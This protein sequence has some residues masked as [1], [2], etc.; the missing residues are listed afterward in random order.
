MRGRVLSLWHGSGGHHYP[1]A[2]NAVKLQIEKLYAVH[3]QDDMNG[4][5]QK[6]QR[7]NDECRNN[8]QVKVS[9]T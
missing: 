5:P 4:T 8:A 6:D 2:P 9:P 3:R 7:D 1:G